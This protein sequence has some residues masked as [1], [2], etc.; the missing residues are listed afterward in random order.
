M[1]CI[2]SCG[3]PPSISNGYFG[4]PSSTLQGGTVTYTCDTGYQISDEVTSAVASCTED[5][6]WQ[7]V[8]NCQSEY[9]NKDQKIYKS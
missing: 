7:N 3:P 4:T 1:H 8:P 2:A 9:I 5:M 6:T